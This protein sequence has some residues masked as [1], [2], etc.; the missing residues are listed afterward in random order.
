[1]EEIMLNEAAPSQLNILQL[2]K[3]R[4]PAFFLPQETLYQSLFAGEMGELEVIDFF[5]TYGRNHWKYIRNYWGNLG[6]AFEN[7]LSIFTN[8]QSYA[9]EIKNYSGVF[10]YKDGLSKMNGEDFNTNCVFQARRASNNMRTILKEQIS[11]KNVN[12]AL[13]FIGENNE[14]NFHSQVDDIQIVQRNQL[15][16]FIQNIAYEENRNRRQTIDFERV[17]ENLETHHIENP[18]ILEPLTLEEMQHVRPGIVCAQCGAFNVEIA[19]KFVS[20]TCGFIELLD[21]AIIR[22]IHEYGT[23]RYNQVLRRKDL[24]R[25]FDGQISTRKL[26]DILSTHFDMAGAGRGTHY[27]NNYMEESIIKKPFRIN[28]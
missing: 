13:I 9:L 17:I 12:G 10:E 7:D 25:F 5:N 6:G 27:L 22:T 14:V 1:M 21:S 3:Q 2:L 11:F 15:K 18:F 20:C 19:R 24:Y 23:L 4:S 8:S 26:T 28:K 16:R